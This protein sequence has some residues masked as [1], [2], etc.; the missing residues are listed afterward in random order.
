M[1]AAT[2]HPTRQ[3]APLLLNRRGSPVSDT[4][5]RSRPTW[6]AI[7]LLA[8]IHVGQSRDR[9][10]RLRERIQE[11]E[12]RPL[13]TG[14]SDDGSNTAPAGRR[15]HER[16][17]R[18]NYNLLPARNELSYLRPL[19][20]CDASVLRPNEA[21]QL[22]RSRWAL[23]EDVV[24][25]PTTM[26]ALSVFLPRWTFSSCVCTHRTDC[27]EEVSRRLALGGIQRRG[28]RETLLK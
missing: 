2:F 28:R 8:E 26:W 24:S 11:L 16:I 7:F 23:A 27:S 19:R 3:R 5:A 14:A 4:V 18:R 22:L 9:R 20:S 10:F 17:A 25:S 15:H 1:R 12:A 21:V 6:F 13:R